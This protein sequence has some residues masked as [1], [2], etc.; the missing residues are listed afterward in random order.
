M[1]SQCEE[2]VDTAVTLEV[3]LQPE[4]ES[5]HGEGAATAAA[6][7]CLCRARGAPATRARRTRELL[8]ACTRPSGRRRE[9]KGGGRGAVG[10]IGRGRG[11]DWQRKEVSDAN[12]CV[13]EMREKPR[14]KGMRGQLPHTEEGDAV[15]AGGATVPLRFS[16]CK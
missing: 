10:K 14:G 2:G 4:M 6:P 11:Q 1:E 13:E 15:T 3:R 8:A 16:F 5:R 9:R 12:G 7:R